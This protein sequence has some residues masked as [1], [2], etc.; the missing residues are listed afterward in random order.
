VP[1]SS[2]EMRGKGAKSA[3]SQIEKEGFRKQ[4]HENDAAQKR[5]GTEKEG[6]KGSRRKDRKGLQMAATK[7]KSK[8]CTGGKN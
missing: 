6:L 5:P 2:P 7:N 8:I 3:K 4:N 1:T